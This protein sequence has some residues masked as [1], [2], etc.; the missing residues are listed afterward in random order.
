MK[1]S[2]WKLQDHSLEHEGLIQ[3]TYTLAEGKPS[4]VPDSFW[5]RFVG[6]ATFKGKRFGYTYFSKRSVPDLLTRAVLAFFSSTSRSEWK[7][8]SIWKPRIYLR[9]GDRIQCFVNLITSDILIINGRVSVLSL[10]DSLN[11]R[12]PVANQ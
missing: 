12:K 1:T 11:T 9:R 7:R 10:I 6:T 2:Y 4:T 3:L 8:V 5:Y